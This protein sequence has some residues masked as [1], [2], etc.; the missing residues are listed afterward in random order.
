M[1]RP[2]TNDPG[3][4]PNEKVTVVFHSTDKDTGP[5]YG[6][7]NGN[8]NPRYRNGFPRDK[9]V[10]MTR[11]ELEVFRN[12]TRTVYKQVHTPRNDGGFEMQN[13]AV[14]VQRFPFEVVR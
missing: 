10:E 9:E 14:K 12:A 2:R 8:I 11:A 4:D 6:S 5:V 13:K 7:L 1:P 3:Y